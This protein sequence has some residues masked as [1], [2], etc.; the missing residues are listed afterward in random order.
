MGSVW[1]HIASTMAK[2]SKLPAW[3]L[4]FLVSLAP[5]YIAP[6]LKVSALWIA[7]VTLIFMY[8]LWIAFASTQDALELAKKDKLPALLNVLS[9]GDESVLLLEQSKLYGQGMGVSIYHRAESGFEVYVADGRVRNIQDN[10]LIQVQ[11]LRWEEQ[12]A[13]LL[14][15]LHRQ[16]R[17][18][19][20][21]IMV[22]PAVVSDLLEQGAQDFYRLL[23][24][25]L[26]SQTETSQ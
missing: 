3:L 5:I 22:K 13:S 1:H 15:R 19:M 10:G 23:Y 4:S 26:Q 21:Q 14:E 6:D 16:E 25:R 24:E 7:P 11:I 2:R 9:Q 12:E 17:T 18:A 8:A 20:D